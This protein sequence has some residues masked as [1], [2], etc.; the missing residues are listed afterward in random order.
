[1]IGVLTSIFYCS[2]QY[3][4]SRQV[5]VPSS[6]FD[7]PGRFTFR[8]EIDNGS[9]DDDDASNKT[10][11]TTRT[12]GFQSMRVATTCV[13]P[14]SM[15]VEGDNRS[16]SYDSNQQGSISKHLLVGVAEYVVW[17]PTRFQTLLLSSSTSQQGDSTSTTSST[18]EGEEAKPYA[19]WP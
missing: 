7:K 5:M 9:N 11:T 8:R 18:M 15:W 6:R 1:M 10:K 17:P 12:R 14:Y 4:L 16:N 13:A 3:T 19:Y 2:K